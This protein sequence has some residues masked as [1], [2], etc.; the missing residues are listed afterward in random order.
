MKRE[1]LYWDS[2]R[3]ILHIERTMVDGYAH[4]EKIVYDPDGSIVSHDLMFY[5]IEI[6][7]LIDKDP[8]VVFMLVLRHGVPML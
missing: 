6:C 3:T 7:S 4:G 1:T 2:D 8:E 5:G